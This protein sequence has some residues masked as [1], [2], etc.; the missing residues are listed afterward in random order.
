MSSSWAGLDGEPGESNLVGE[1]RLRHRLGE[2]VSPTEMNLL[3][4]V[5]TV[6][7]MYDSPLEITPFDRNHPKFHLE[8][9]SSPAGS[10]KGKLI[11]KIRH[12]S[13]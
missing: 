5:A 12:K 6:S 10:T 7:R 2:N 3:S 13:S 11:P 9:Q 4:K 8:I 1:R